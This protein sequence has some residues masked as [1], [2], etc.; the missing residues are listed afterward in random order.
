MCSSDLW[1]L[2]SDTLDGCVVTNHDTGETLSVYD[3]TKLDSWDLYDVFLSGPAA[4]LTVENPGAKTDRELIV[5]RDS[6]GSSLVPLLL[7]GYSK[8]GGLRACQYRSGKLSDCTGRCA[9]RGHGGSR[10]GGSGR[11][12]CRF[13]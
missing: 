4:V 13:S 2:E 11:R 1:L 7:P 12:S 5:F 3:R 6:F 9:Q 8:V 10:C